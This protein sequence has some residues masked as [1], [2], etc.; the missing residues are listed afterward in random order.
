MARHIGYN[1]LGALNDIIMLYPDSN[2]WDNE[3]DIDEHNYNKKT[4]VFPSAFK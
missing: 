1:D 4:G 2:C 3:G